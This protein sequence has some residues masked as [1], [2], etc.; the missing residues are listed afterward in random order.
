MT[1]SLAISHADEHVE[2]GHLTRHGPEGSPAKCRI[3]FRSSER[4]ALVLEN[5]DFFECLIDLRR[6]LEK[7][8]G[9]V[10]CQGARRDVF[11]SPMMRSSGC[12]TAY[13]MR[14]GKPANEKEV[15]QIFDAAPAN[16]VVSVLEQLAYYHQWLGSL[17]WEQSGG[18]WYNADAGKTP[19]PGELEE[20][21]RY[22]NG[23]ISRIRGSYGPDDEIPIEAIEGFWRVDA[24]GRIVGKFLKNPRYDPNQVRT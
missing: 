10:L 20:A 5:D 2:E 19:R 6:L 9:R 22:P 18:R 23:T 1:D 8:G 15:V 17:G 7:D 3:E 4:D 14:M 12:A 11:P 21:K 13:V 24:E 16:L